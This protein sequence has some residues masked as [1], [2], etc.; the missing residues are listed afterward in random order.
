MKQTIRQT[1]VTTGSLGS[2]YLDLY[3]QVKG[4]RMSIESISNMVKKLP[5]G[6][7]L[8][9]DFDGVVKHL[10]SVSQRKK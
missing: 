1:P 4:A 9:Q 2:E 10:F 8:K 7:V 3:K 5:K 6:D